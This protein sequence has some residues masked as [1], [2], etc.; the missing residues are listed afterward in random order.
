[1]LSVRVG[2]LLCVVLLCC[3]MYVMCAGVCVDVLGIV[4]CA[5]R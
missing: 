2:G 1:V 4:L 3:Y 5:L